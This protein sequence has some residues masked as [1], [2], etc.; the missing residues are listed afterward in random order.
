[1]SPLA[2]GGGIMPMI[3]ALPA[4][5][6][7][8]RPAIL[9]T[10]SLIDYG[11]SHLDGAF[12]R[13]CIAHILQTMRS[14]GKHYKTAACMCLPKADPLLYLSSLFLHHDLLGGHAPQ[15]RTKDLVTT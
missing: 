5:T 6:L 3:A 15:N 8:S 7:R 1:M 11:M 2:S 14:A 12:C 9:D 10:K 13:G 4:P